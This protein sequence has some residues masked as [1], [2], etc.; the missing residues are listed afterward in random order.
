MAALIHN[1]L[2]LL[3][4]PSGTSLAES[5]RGSSRMHSQIVALLVPE[6]CRRAALL[7]RRADGQ[8]ALQGIDARVAHAARIAAA[9]CD[10]GSGL[11]DAPATGVS[12]T[13]RE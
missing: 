2:I 13:G 4:F 1:Y 10:D 8:L 12:P 9:W 7:V 11:A 3:I 5:P 6:G